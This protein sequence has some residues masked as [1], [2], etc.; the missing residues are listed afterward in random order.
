[1]N[2]QTRFNVGDKVFTIDKETLKM[3][4]FTVG[5]VHIWV[6]DGARVSYYA[7]KDEVVSYGESYDESVCF[8]SENELLSYITTRERT[9]E[10]DRGR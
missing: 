10:D 9:V 4:E 7:L 2:I 1:M 8:A 5:S 6:N 3:K